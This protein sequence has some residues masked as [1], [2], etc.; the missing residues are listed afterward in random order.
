MKKFNILILLAFFLFSCGTDR[1]L[2]QVASFGGTIEKAKYLISKGANVNSTD[3]YGRTPLFGASEFGSLEMVKLLIEKGADV[4]ATDGWNGNTC[5][6]R[7]FANNQLEIAKVL[8]RNGAK[9]NIKNGKGYTPW[10]LYAHNKTFMIN[11][12]DLVQILK[13][14]GITIDS[15]KKARSDFYYEESTKPYNS[16]VY[17]LTPREKTTET[18]T[19]NAIYTQTS[20]SV[21]V[22]DY[23]SGISSL[24]EAIGYLD[25]SIDAYPTPEAYLRRGI[26]RFLHNQDGCPD[27]CKAKELG[28]ELTIEFLTACPNC[29]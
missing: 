8:I 19:A 18:Q 3:S 5:L 23:A 24:N 6:H 4:N 16:A 9:I 26:C 21:S 2:R 28:A 1:R 17:M 27:I 10:E 29:K 14:K 12:S 11:D 15:L 22:L 20:S 7:A 25:L 13:E